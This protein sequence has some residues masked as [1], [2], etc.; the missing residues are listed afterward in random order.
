M[1]ELTVAGAPLPAAPQQR[2]SLDWEMPQTVLRREL[3]SREIPVLD[4]L[5]SFQGKQCLYANNRHFVP[6]GQHLAARRI[7]SFLL[8][9]PGLLPGG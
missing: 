8:R 6:E 1:S 5:D 2:G 3:A 7:A 9:S 4:L